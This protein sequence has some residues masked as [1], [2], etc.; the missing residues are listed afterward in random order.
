MRKYIDDR[1][2]SNRGK[3]YVGISLIHI[4]YIKFQA[5][6]C[7]RAEKIIDVKSKTNLET[8]YSMLF[9]SS[10]KFM[11]TIQ[12]GQQS[13]NL[14]MTLESFH[15]ILLSTQVNFFR[16]ILLFHSFLLLIRSLSHPLFF[17]LFIN[18]AYNENRLFLMAMLLPKVSGN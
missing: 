7:G 3:N 6:F 13:V 8:C 16:V 1:W 12:K 14:A 2:H 15:V 17:Y 11:N 4:L 18:D 5:S 10:N 9:L